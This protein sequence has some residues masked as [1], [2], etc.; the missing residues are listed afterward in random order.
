MKQNIEEGQAT[1]YLPLQI[2][3]LQWPTTHTHTHTH[4]C[5]HTH[6]HTYAHVWLQWLEYCRFQSAGQ[7][8]TTRWTRPCTNC[9]CTPHRILREFKGQGWPTNYHGNKHELNF[10]VQILML[11]HFSQEDNGA[12]KPEQPVIADIGRKAGVL[13]PV[14]PCGTKKSKII[15]LNQTRSKSWEWLALLPQPFCS[16]YGPSSLTPRPS[17]TLYFASSPDFIL[18]LWKKTRVFST[19]VR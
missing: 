9:W 2:F 18:Q 3:P 6:T 7:W 10:V 14:Q 5:T 1:V 16:E 12:S 15:K 4:T 8:I 19:A 13:S 11:S 17:C